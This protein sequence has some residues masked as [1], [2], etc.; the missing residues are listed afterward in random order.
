MGNVLVVSLYQQQVIEEE[1]LSL[2]LGQFLFVRLI[3]IRHLKQT[4]AAHQAPVGHSE[5]LR[6]C[7]VKETEMTISTEDRLQ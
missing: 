5:D 7:E 2:Q 4:T 3:G 1:N 6:G